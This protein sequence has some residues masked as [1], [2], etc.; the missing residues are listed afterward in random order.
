M[1]KKNDLKYQII[2]KVFFFCFLEIFSQM[3]YVFLIFERKNKTL[4]NKIAIPFRTFEYIAAFL[5]IPPFGTSGF[6][7][8]K[9]S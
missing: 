2:E 4:L 1:K 5:A 3:K 6:F 9:T 8:H 7:K